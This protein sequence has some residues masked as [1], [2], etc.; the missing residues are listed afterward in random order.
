MGIIPIL[1]LAVSAAS[2][3]AQ[4][5]AAGNAAAARREANAVQTA[6]QQFR[7]QLA[8]R[9]AAR[10]ERIRRARLINTSA[11][12]GT[13]GSSGY[14]GAISSLGANLGSA[15]AAQRNEA[16]TSIGISR[17]NQ[18]AADAENFGNSFAAFGGMIQSGL[19]LWQEYKTNQAT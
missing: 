7:D 16:A 17:A 8:R 5:V 19:N 3:V 13:M 18:R 2:T 11:T 15:F 4:V 6:G 12:S 9:R 14:V 10:E 1:S